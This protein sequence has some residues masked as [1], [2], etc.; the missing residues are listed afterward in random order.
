[1]QPTT[2]A[3][4]FDAGSSRCRAVTLCVQGV[5]LLVAAGGE[6]L[7]SVPLADIRI[8][9][10]LAAVPHQ[11]HLPDG[12]MISVADHAFV[13]FAFPPH[14]ARIWTGW[15]D[16]AERHWRWVLALALL[17]LA[18]AAAAYRIGLPWAAAQMAAHIPDEYVR[19]ASEEIYTA[20]HEEDILN[21]STLTDAEMARAERLFG[22]IAAPGLYLKVH[23]FA[24]FGD[25]S[26][27][28]AF[29][30]PDG[31]IILT[32]DIVR[33]L[34]DDELHAVLAHE[35]GHVHHRHGI[36]MMLQ[37]IGV[38]AFVF[39]ITGDFTGMSLS[40]VPIV[41]ANSHYS[42]DFE[43]DAD[44]YAAEHLLARGKSPELLASG[45]RKL[46]EDME[47]QPV[48]REVRHSLRKEQEERDPSE[49]P[50]ELKARA[51]DRAA[52]E[53][54]LN[55]GEAEAEDGIGAKALEQLVQVLST[56]PETEERANLAEACGLDA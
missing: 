56:H 7:R 46:E 53:E 55:T 3:D 41:L 43:R 11:L 45:L 33:L 30:F 39:F 37:A 22:E 47:M 14:R 42:R 19:Q 25:L 4:W 12:V 23:R 36:R 29:A 15:V 40:L 18:L 44:C 2:N 27:A 49:T 31:M 52:E 34:S 38:S 50:E 17:A 9:E 1:M 35:A 8:S 16:K 54:R 10:R 13:D 24:I 26:I 6:T 32:D 5:E 51:Q 21:P 48:K 28:N 20:L